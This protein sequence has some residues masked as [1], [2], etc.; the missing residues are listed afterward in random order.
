MEIKEKVSHL[1]GLMEGMEYDTHSKEG[2]LI[3]AIVDILDDMADEIAGL[4]EDVET[5][6]DYADEL[7]EDLGEVEREIYGD[8]D[9]DDY[10]DEPK[11]SRKEKKEKHGFFG[12]KKKNDEDEDDDIEFLDL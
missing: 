10:D 1:K 11:K 2:K 6:Y 5:L 7:D 8:F 12:R 4:D 3:A 9:E